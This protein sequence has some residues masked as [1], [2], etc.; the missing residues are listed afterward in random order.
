MREHLQSALQC[1][2]PTTLSPD[3]IIKKVMTTKILLI[4]EEK[5]EL[6][7]TTANNDISDLGT[8]FNL[9]SC[10]CYNNSAKWTDEEDLNLHL[11]SL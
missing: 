3:E 10:D 11:S 9:V 5:L 8:T 1:V 6:L 7:T 2:R 4:P